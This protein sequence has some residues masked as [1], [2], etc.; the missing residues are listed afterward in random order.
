MSE[1]KKEYRIDITS[2]AVEH[3]LDAAKGFIKRLVAPS[4]EELGLLIKDQISLWRF[5]NQVKILNKAKRICELNKINVKAIS[6]KLLCPYLENASLE[7]DEDLQDKWATLLANMADSEQN[8]ENQVFPYILSQLSKQEMVFLDKNYKRIKDKQ[9]ELQTKKE[10]LE[11]DKSENEEKYKAEI[12]N[13][14]EK[15]RASG[16]SGFHNV[17]S[18]LKSQIVH[19]N[20]LLRD[21]YIRNIAINNENNNLYKID[22]SD[23]KNFELANITRLGLLKTTYTIN[24]GTQSLELPAPTLSNSS[25]YVNFDIDV[26]NEEEI[27]M[28]DLGLLFI[29][30]CNYKKA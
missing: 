29:S 24:A 1:E 7:D 16:F 8:I 13:L 26:A 5:N 28:T 19:I 10:L 30:A 12:A 9:I 17:N 14:Q 27:V 11:K 25:S 20:S 4:A 6:P 23:I 3:G 15:I 2:G 22:A 18:E 21:F